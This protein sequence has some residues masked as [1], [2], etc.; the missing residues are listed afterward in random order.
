MLSHGP[1]ASCWCYILYCLL[2]GPSSYRY[3]VWWFC[4][5]L[6]EHMGEVQWSHIV[7]NTRYNT[8]Y[9]HHNVTHKHVIYGHNHQ[10]YWLQ[11]SFFVSHRGISVFLHWSFLVQIAWDGPVP[12][13]AWLRSTCFVYYF[14]NNSALFFTLSSSHVNICMR[15]HP[16]NG[17]SYYVLRSHL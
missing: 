13:V 9:I 10:V 16:F 5:A 6:E 2:S 8:E 7:I 4:V 1:L 14:N 3:T 15:G 12:F 17:T 11:P